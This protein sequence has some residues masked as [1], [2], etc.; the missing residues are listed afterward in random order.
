MPQKYSE[1]FKKSSNL[2]WHF[3]CIA[4]L[5][6]KKG[7]QES[8]KF[9]LLCMSLPVLIGVSTSGSRYHGL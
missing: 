6:N 9:L 4:E 1:L 5:Q 8:P 2:Q 3:T 7:S